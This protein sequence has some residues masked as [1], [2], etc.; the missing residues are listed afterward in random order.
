MTDQRGT[1]V[2]RVLAALADY[3]SHVEQRGTDTW[4]AQCPADGHDDRTASLAIAQGDAGAVVWCHAGCD[5]KTAVLPPL[6]LGF[7]DLF[8]Q[9][10]QVRDRAPRR[11][12]AE[13]RYTDEHGEL[14]FVKVRYE[15]KDFAVKRPDGSGGWTYKLSRDT[16]RVLY[17]LPEVLA[18]VRDG[19]TV[20][21]VEGEKDA[22]RLAGLGHVATCNFDGAAKDGQRP[23]W[24]P[25][26]TGVLRGADV[27]IIA[28]RDAPGIAHA[29][30]IAASLNGKAKS[31]AIMQAAV[32]RARADVSDHLDA[33]L[34]LGD[35]VPVKPDPP[36]SKAPWP[37][38]PAPAEGGRF[39]REYDAEGH[40]VYDPQDPLAPIKE[41]VKDAPPEQLEGRVAVAVEAMARFGM[42]TQTKVSARVYV[43][44][45]KL[46][47]V[48]Q[49]DEIL[50]EAKRARTRKHTSPPSLPA[51]DTAHLHTPPAWA[52]EQ[53]ILARMVRTLRVCTGLV[54]ENRNAKLVYLA[55]TSRLLDKQVSIVVKGL[56]SSGKSYTI[57]CVTVL[58]PPEAVYTM[59]AMSERALI[60]LDESMEHRTIILYEATAL[61]EGR[62]KAEDNQ[63]AYI[64]R[65]L[66]SEGHIE[67]PV[68]LRQEDGTLRT[69]KII[70]PGPTNLVTSTTSISLHPENETRMLSLPSNDSQA[71]TR[72]VMVISSDDGPGREPDVG[73]W[74]DYQ[75]WLSGASHEV[76][77]PYARCVAAQVPPVAVRLRRD[78]NAIRA[79]IRTH[80]MM[81]QLNREADG[82]GRIIATLD[83]YTAVRS[84]V[85]ELVAEGIG[86]TVPESVR[87]T[88]ETVK[89]LA[90]DGA[91]R[92]RRDRRRGGRCPQD[93]AVSRDQAAVHGTGPRVPGQLGGQAGQ[94]GPVRPRRPDARRDGGD[95]TARPDL[96]RS[97]RTPSAG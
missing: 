62:E 93:R 38:G 91:H 33:G 3:G 6:K 86:A 5:T 4:A 39:G 77:I 30:A 15:P 46:L 17:R 16:R 92:G 70:V 78:W 1:A 53:D 95:A 65:S 81:H 2:K 71:Q 20:F 55:I 76:T 88:V 84:L 80:A 49:F 67:Y 90:E 8:D 9:P 28:D 57:E 75:R 43:K 82:H 63:T 69:E 74:L 45:Q 79:L 64:V 37:D 83:D 47:T 97:V 40:L 27:V 21:L 51:A 73:D 19:K 85:A 61:R 52:S 23:K 26:Y 87:Q 59:T 60:Y 89:K 14:L 68:V 58:F 36:A 94:A 11:V 42:D 10:R 18:A 25:E 7:P 50:E 13:Y 44:K 72:R 41:A 54:G 24:R 31:V 48:S 96:H 34:D 22:G 66:L 29:Q 56:S 12:A 35:L 32:D